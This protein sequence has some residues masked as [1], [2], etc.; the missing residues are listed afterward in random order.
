MYYIKYYSSPLGS[1]IIAADDTGL[2]GL[3]FEREALDIGQRLGECAQQSTPVLEQTAKWLDI[4]FSGRQPDFTPP[5]KPRGTAFRQ[6]VWALLLKIPYGQ[7]T[8]YG[9]LAREIAAQSGRAKMSAQAIGGAVGHN[10]I[11]IIIP[12]HRVIGTDGSLTG[13]AGGLDKKAAL[14]KLEGITTA[15]L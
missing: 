12:C 13:Y 14:L 5:L 15:Y 10:N 8:T 4:Y 11:S 2:V 1:I 6:S 9:A 7:T 3:W